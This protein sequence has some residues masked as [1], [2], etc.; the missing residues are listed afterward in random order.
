MKLH[1]LLS[2][3][4][5]F[6]LLAALFMLPGAAA[7][8]G[9]VDGN[10]VVQAADARLCLRQAVGLERYARGS[11]Q[12]NACD[13]NSDGNVAAEDA[14]LILRA[15][16]GLGDDSAPQK[17]F[18]VPMEIWKSKRCII[19]L[20]GYQTKYD[21][22]Y[23]GMVQVCTLSVKDVD[24]TPYDLSIESV[25][26]NGMQMPNPEE[27]GIQVHPNSTETLQFMIPGSYF[28]ISQSGNAVI[29]E[30]S[31]RVM[32][33]SIAEQ[34]TFYAPITLY[35][36]NKAGGNHSAANSV[37]YKSNH[38]DNDFIF[39][40]RDGKIGRRTY[41]GESFIDYF[42]AVFYFKNKSNRDLK[43]KFTDISV[44]DTLKLKRDISLYVFAGT[45]AQPEIYLDP[46]FFYNAYLKN[47]SKVSYTLSVYDTDTGTTLFTKG[48]T[49]R[50]TG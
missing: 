12:Y 44:D 23:G 39:G 10:G 46:N 16:V 20:T 22:D 5:A 1:K 13:Y 2:I 8:R 28:D 30:L 40:F 34:S 41:N 42:Y 6:L 3:L 17:K 43:V 24:T 18:S 50:V 26:I 45:A 35:P 33:F 14:R 49:I 32:Y 15:A 25:T 7:V 19:T 4:L 27:F 36:T 47:I 29:E 21:A 9:D 31:F 38:E 48:Y 37:S 11:S